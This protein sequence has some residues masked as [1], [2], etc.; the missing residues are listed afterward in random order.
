[1]SSLYPRYA[2][3]VSFIAADIDPTETPAMVRDYQKTTGFNW[4]YVMADAATVER[5]TVLRTDTKFAVDRRGIIIY[6]GGYG[7]EDAPTWKSVLDTL[8]HT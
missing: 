2:G 1:L 8:V 5:F 6:Y 7:G 4:T 3:Q